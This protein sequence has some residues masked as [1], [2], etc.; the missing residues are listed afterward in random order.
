MWVNLRRRRRAEVVGPSLPF[1][2]LMAKTLPLPLT[3]CCPPLA[4]LGTVME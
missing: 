2:V 4:I 1:G 3:A